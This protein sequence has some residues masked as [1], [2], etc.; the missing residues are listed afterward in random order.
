MTPIWLISWPPCTRSQ[1]NKL[2]GLVMSKDRGE[3]RIYATKVANKGHS[4]KWGLVP[5]DVLCKGS[6]C[7]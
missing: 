4:W 7:I 1:T 5:M 6:A 3:I 2:K